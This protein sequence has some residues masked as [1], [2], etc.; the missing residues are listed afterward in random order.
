MKLVAQRALIENPDDDI[1]PKYARHDGD[2]EIDRLT[3]DG[4][5]EA[6][7]LGY[8]ALRNVQLGNHLDPGDY[9]LRAFMPSNLGHMIQYAV[10]A[11]FD[12]ES[13]RIALQVDIARPELDRIING[14]I[15][16][17]DDVAFVVRDRRQRYL[18]QLGDCG[19]GLVRL[20]RVA[21]YGPQ[22]VFT[23]AQQCRY[24]VA[25]CDVK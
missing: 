14:R 9:L 16:Q 20:A 7:I 25:M 15:D 23:G 5:L 21:S 10:D 22:G 24:V 11:K 17:T 6:P 12:V 4:E 8:A 13:A 2:A 18:L 3:L 19:T 1:L